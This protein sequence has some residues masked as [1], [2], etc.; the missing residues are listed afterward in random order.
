MTGGNDF[1]PLRPEV[2]VL[3]PHLFPSA[4]RG[5][6]FPVWYTTT[7]SGKVDK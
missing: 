5:R 6:C 7:E 3:L 2:P 4:T 1:F